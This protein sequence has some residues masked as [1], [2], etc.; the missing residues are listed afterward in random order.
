MNDRIKSSGE[1]MNLFAR[2]FEDQA[3]EAPSPH[4]RKVKR[5]LAKNARKLAA[6][7]DALDR[8]F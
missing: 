3:N 2:M 7:S 1:P 8:R 4:A 6:D 5:N